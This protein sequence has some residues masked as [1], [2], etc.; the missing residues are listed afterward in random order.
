MRKSTR[1][2]RVLTIH[3]LGTY[4]S[5]TNIK[6]CSLGT[7]ILYWSLQLRGNMKIRMNSKGTLCR[8]AG[9]KNMSLPMKTLLLILFSKLNGGIQAIRDYHHC[10][11]NNTGNKQFSPGKHWICCLG[12]G[13]KTDLMVPLSAHSY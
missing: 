10:R 5:G 7:N 12:P 4:I 1:N 13:V 9:H 11:G 3:R 2:P 8:P 6:Y